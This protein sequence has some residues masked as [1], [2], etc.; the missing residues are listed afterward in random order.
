MAQANALIAEAVANAAFVREVGMLIS[1]L[2]KIA[3]IVVGAVIVLIVINNNSNVDFRSGTKSSQG[4]DST[5]RQRWAWYP[6]YVRS[7]CF[8]WVFLTNGK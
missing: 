3:L 8:P 4:A 2:Q 6:T 1:L 5:L 7:L